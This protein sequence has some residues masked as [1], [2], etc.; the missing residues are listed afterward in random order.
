MLEH[1]FHHFDPYIDFIS[2]ADILKS[3]KGRAYGNSIFNST[4]S[5]KSGG[6]R[7][8]LDNLYKH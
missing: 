3:D 2:I 4:G 1:R 8:I 6:N 7:D 5:Q